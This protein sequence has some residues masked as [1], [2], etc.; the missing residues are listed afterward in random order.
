MT[1]K[2]ENGLLKIQKDKPVLRWPKTTEMIETRLRELYLMGKKWEFRELRKSVIGV[3][4]ET[5]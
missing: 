1:T 4:Y 2:L 3:I 5:I